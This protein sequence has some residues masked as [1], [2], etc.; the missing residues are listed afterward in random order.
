MRTG[1]SPKQRS[2]MFDVYRDELAV[3]RASS[4]RDGNLPGIQDSRGDT[5]PI[6]R[7]PKQRRGS[8][9]AGRQAL[10]RRVRL[11]GRGELASLPALLPGQRIS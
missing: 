4:H 3:E 10:S 1:N 11:G 6:Q 2:E 7:N 5:A 8:A 9:P